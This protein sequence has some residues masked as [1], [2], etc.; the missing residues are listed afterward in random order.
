MG[1]LTLENLEILLSVLEEII[2][3]IVFIHRGGNFLY[4]NRPY[5]EAL[6]YSRE[7]VLNMPFWEI[8]HPD[9][10]EMVKERA[11]NA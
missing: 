4:V 10:R 6:G 8:V 11:L 2:P 3:G 9:H 1:K 5:A 7:E